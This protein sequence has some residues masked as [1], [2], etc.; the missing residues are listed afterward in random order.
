MGSFLPRPV[1]A[2]YVYKTEGV[3][4]ILKELHRFMR[5][6]V[7]QYMVGWPYGGSLIH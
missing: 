3:S 5:F 2:N 6:V 7:V 1:V 4:M